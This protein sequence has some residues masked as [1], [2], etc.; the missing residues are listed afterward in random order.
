MPIVRKLRGRLLGMGYSPIYINNPYKGGFVLKWLSL[1]YPYRFIFSME[2]NKKLY[3][4]KSET[5]SQKL[6]MNKIKDDITGLFEI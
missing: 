5:R 6:K 4:N 2:I 1:M 3:T